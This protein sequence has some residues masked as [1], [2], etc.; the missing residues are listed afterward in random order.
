MYNT[1]PGAYKICA[2]YVRKTPRKDEAIGLLL[3]CGVDW[4]SNN[5]MERID[6]GALVAAITHTSRVQF[7]G[8]SSLVRCLLGD[9]TG[10]GCNVLVE[11]NQGEFVKSFC[12]GSTVYRGGIVSDCANCMLSGVPC[13]LRMPKAEPSSPPKTDVS[14]DKT[15]TGT[16]LKTSNEAEVPAGVPRPNT[17]LFATPGSSDSSD[18]DATPRQPSPRYP[19]PGPAE[20]VISRATLISPKA[21]SGSPRQRA[22]VA[23]KVI[24]RATVLVLTD[25]LHAHARRLLGMYDNVGDKEA[26]SEA[27]EV[28]YTAAR[29]IRGHKQPTRK[30][31]LDAHDVLHALA[32]RMLGDDTDG[33][34]EVFAAAKAIREVLKVR[35]GIVQFGPVKPQLGTGQP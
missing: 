12:S 27:A 24:N 25:L 30:D 17:P 5:L 19:P 3:Q 6:S 20:N 1:N 21:R 29:E 13:P 8:K 23:K 10:S 4:K 18:E 28:V 33:F 16:G 11:P 32:R 34:D 26:V 31:V 15:T 7:D 9:C 2:V 22:P 35:G 14:A